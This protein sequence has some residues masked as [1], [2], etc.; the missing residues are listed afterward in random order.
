MRPMRFSL[1]LLLTCV[2]PAACGGVVSSEEPVAG[3]AIAEH[4]YFF[5]GG[6]YQNS[7]SYIGGMYYD[8]DP[9]DWVYT[10][11]LSRPASAA[12]GSTKP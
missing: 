10:A 3:V 4:G 6:R 2:L 11:D 7:D 8:K 1:L 5:V 9:N 12:Q